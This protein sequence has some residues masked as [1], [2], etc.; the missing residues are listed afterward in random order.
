[1]FSIASTQLNIRG[2]GTTFLELSGDA[3]AAFELVYP[4]HQEQSAI[5]AFLD[6]ETAKIDA[7]VAEQER[8]IELL[9]EK[10][11]AVISHAVTKGLDPNVPMKDSGVEWLGEVPEHW[12]VA[13]LRRFVR[14]VQTG[15]TPSASPPSTDIEDG[16]DWF[17][18]GD[19]SGPIRLGS[20]SKKV[21]PEAIEQGE[22][23]VFPAGAVL[24]VGIGA[25][26]GKIGYLLALASANQQINAILPNAEVEGLFLAYSLSSKTAE[27]RN[28]S[29]ASTIGI[30]NQEKTKEIWVAVPPLCEQETIAKFLDQD[31]VTSDALINEAQRAIDLLKERRSALISAAVTGKI[32]VRGLADATQ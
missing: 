3:L 18:P 17:T 9:K 28:L 15:G 23:K 5:A 4:P 27:M 19:F 25:T 12:E 2:K 26:L 1:M 10:R 24:V 11:Q 8:L 32:D 13:K 31:G 14:A 30:M 21:P 16:T 22:A 6:R 29:N 7:L 20:A